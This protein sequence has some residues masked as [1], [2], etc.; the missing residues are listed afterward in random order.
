MEKEIV[1]ITI[2]NLDADSTTIPRLP[3]LLDSQKSTRTCNLCKELFIDYVIERRG[4]GA[5]YLFFFDFGRLPQ[6]QVEYLDSGC[7]PL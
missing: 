6:E 2:D 7:R 3:S 4:S 1:K 5:T